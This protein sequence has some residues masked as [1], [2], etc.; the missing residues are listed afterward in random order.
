MP[1]MHS[2]TIAFEACMVSVWCVH[3]EEMAGDGGRAFVDVC[4]GPALSRWGCTMSGD[5]NV[6]Y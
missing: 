1:A 3:G 6:Y 2:I 5:A 4:M